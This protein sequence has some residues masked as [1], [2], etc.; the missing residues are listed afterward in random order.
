MAGLLAPVGIIVGITWGG[1]SPSYPSP[2]AP[3]GG[4][5]PQLTASWHELSAPGGA[6]PAWTQ[7]SDVVSYRGKLVAA[8]GVARRVGH[9]GCPQSCGTVIWISQTGRRWRPVFATE[10]GTPGNALVPTRHGLAVLNVGMQSLDAGSVRPTKTSLFDPLVHQ[11]PAW[12]TAPASKSE[13]QMVLSIGEDNDGPPSLA[14]PNSNLEQPVL[15]SADGVHWPSGAQQQT[16]TWQS[17]VKIG[18]GFVGITQTANDTA[19]LWSRNDRSWSPAKISIPPADVAELASR[20]SGAVL[21]L[22]PSRYPYRPAPAQLW[23]SNNGRSWTRAT[24]IG[25]PL[26]IRDARGM[27]PTLVAADGGFV[28]FD[29]SNAGIW[30]S[31]TGRTWARVH[32]ASSPPANLEPQSVSIDH[33]SLLIAEQGQRLLRRTR[34]GPVYQP[35]PVSFWR[36][37]LTI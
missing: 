6:L 21:E 24:M 16:Y 13:G 33:N 32:A 1:G 15:S 14:Q 10:Q 19:V 5:G 11:T 7:I 22:V 18:D 9:L 26:M 4:S 37:R 12:L 23:Y 36:L 25:A 8:G 17:T 2:L 29:R 3:A 31:K 30:W 20:P 35:G 34:F 28:A 27:M